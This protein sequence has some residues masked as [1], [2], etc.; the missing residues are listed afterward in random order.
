MAVR[1]R[2]QFIIIV[3]AAVLLIATG[4]TVYLVLKPESQDTR[5]GAAGLADIPAFPGAEGFGA[6]TAGGR[7]G[8]VIEVTNLND[9][10]SGSLREAIETTGARIVVF[11][12]S[13]TIH[14]ESDLHVKEPY[15]TIAGQTAPG[16]GI[17]IADQVFKIEETHD[18]VV[19]YIRSRRGDVDCPSNDDSISIHHSQNV[20]LDHVSASWSIDET[21]SVTGDESNNITVQW[22]IISESLNSSC[23]EKSDAHGY[24]SIIAQK[25]IDKHG[26]T[27]HHN[28]FANHSSRSPRISGREGEE[29]GPIIDFRNNVIY[30]W[31]KR[32]AYSVEDEFM[33]VNFVNNYIKPGPATTQNRNYAIV[34]TE[35]GLE[36]YMNGNYHTLKGYKDWELV[37]GNASKSDSPF[38]APSVTTSSAEEAYEDVL[39]NSGA[40]L[41]DRDSVDERVI[42]DVRNNTGEIIDSQE[43]VGGWPKLLTTAP[44]DD[45]D[46]DGMPDFWEDENGFDKNNSSDA[47]G[48]A[49][50]DGYTNIEEYLNDTDPV[51]PVCTPD[52]EGKECGDDGCG[53]SCGD[54]ESGEACTDNQCESACTPNCDGKEC[55]SDGCGGSCGTCESGKVC[56]ESFVCVFSSSVDADLNDDGTVDDSDYHIFID[57]YMDCRTGADCNSRS[58]LD[59]DGVVSIADYE[60]FVKEY[61]KEND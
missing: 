32:P 10:G 61:K 11:R 23:H 2:K 44:P 30:N 13:G 60:L 36:L 31:E 25:L 43:D 53:G 35:S 19:R 33:K 6:Y 18:V 52:C 40:V 4:V 29:P 28:L 16:G 14:L 22:S 59:G 1:I 45:S 21:L 24:A 49:D 50:D 17:T 15:I 37:D 54:C 26:V 48:D 7:G 51:A 41:P 20:I 27:F 58:D 47:V 42:S 34:N 55:G 46:H 56:D 3:V 12:V 57:D 8:Q 39:N 9:S 5:S 38:D